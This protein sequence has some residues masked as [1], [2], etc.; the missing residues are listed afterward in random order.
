MVFTVG[1][2]TAVI[3]TASTQA[4]PAAKERRAERSYWRNYDGR[5]SYY[6]QPD[7]SWY[8]TDGNNWYYN[9]NSAWKVY[10]FDR[11]FGTDDFERGD[12]RAPGPDVKIVTPNHKIYIDK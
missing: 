6:Y 1:S 3:D 10:N 12:Y 7:K 4:G 5:W 2:V 9:N 8:Y 11:K